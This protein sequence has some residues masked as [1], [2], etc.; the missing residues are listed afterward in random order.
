MK[1]SKDI[2]YIHRFIEYFNEVLSWMGLSLEI[3]FWKNKSI[4]SLIGKIP[5]LIHFPWVS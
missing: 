1:F 4:S 2:V 3:I 5:Y